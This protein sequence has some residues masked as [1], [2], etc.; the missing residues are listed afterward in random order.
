[1]C[2]QWQKWGVEHLRSL[3]QDFI[4][5]LTCAKYACEIISKQL[6]GIQSTQKFTWVY[7]SVSCIRWETRVMFTSITCCNRCIFEGVYMLLI[8]GSFLTKVTLVLTMFL[9]EQTDLV[10][11]LT[12][13]RI[14][15]TQTDI[16]CLSPI[17]F[18]V[19]VMPLPTLF[20][21][22][23][24]LFTHPLRAIGPI[25]IPNGEH[26]QSIAET[27]EKWSIKAMN[28]K[29]LFWSQLINSENYHSNEEFKRGQW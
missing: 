20:K 21:L 13:G 17:D 23:R 2:M 18:Q 3:F 26:A 8:H 15:L 28:V 27:S 14:S 24:H 4:C 7:F 22:R 9:K 5:C 10:A 25:K 19:P 6:S 16:F 12:C 11:A 29:W 1:M